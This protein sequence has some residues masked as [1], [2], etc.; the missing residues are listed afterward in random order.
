MDEILLLILFIGGGIFLAGFAVGYVIG[1]ASNTS[2]D[3]D[4]RLAQL[5]SMLRETIQHFERQERTTPPAETPAETPAG[6][7]AIVGPESPWKPSSIAL[8][9]PPASP[10]PVFSTIITPKTEEAGT[11]PEKSV[12]PLP[13]TLTP[14]PEPVPPSDAAAL[15]SRVSPI[16][17]PPLVAANETSLEMS[18]EETPPSLVEHPWAA[19]SASEK[20]GNRE[21]AD[22]LETRHSRSEPAGPRPSLLAQLW[23]HAN[24][25]ALY[26][27]L[28]NIWVLIGV[29]ILF[30]GLVFLVRLA[31]EQDFFT[32]PLRL[33]SAALIGS[34]LLALGWRLREKRRDLALI[35]QGGG[36]GALYLTVVAAVQLYELLPSTVAFV[37]L[38]CLVVLSTFLAI[39]QNSQIMAHV[40]NGAGFLAPILISTGSGNYIALFSYYIL[41]NLGIVG[42]SWYRHWRTLHLTGFVCTTLIGGLWG[43]HS[44]LPVMLP[45]IE[46]FLLVFFLLFTYLALAGSAVFQTRSL[47]TFAGGPPET[48]TDMPLTFATP[49]VFMLYQAWLTQGQPF[50]LAFTALALGVFYL[51]IAAFLWKHRAHT[52]VSDQLA[53]PS[54]TDSAFLGTLVK[55]GQSAYRLQAEIYLSFSIVFLN[56]ALPLAL[57]ELDIPDLRPR[58]LALAWVLEGAALYWLGRRHDL[59]LFRL[60]AAAG[61]VL[62]IGFQ[63]DTLMSTSAISSG[64][65]L[66][67]VLG[68]HLLGAACLASAS[69]ACRRFPG[70]SPAD[71]N[72]NF[73]HVFLGTAVLWW[74]GSWL[75][76]TAT[77]AYTAEILLAGTAAVATA[78]LFAARRLEWPE[79]RFATFLSYFP[80]AYLV[81]PCLPPAAFLLYANSSA[82]I[83]GFFHA[84]F[85]FFPVKSAAILLF[86]VFEGALLSPRLSDH[87]NTINRIRLAVLPSLALPALVI[88]ASYLVHSIPLLT[89]SSIAPLSSL[90]CTLLWPVLIVW[91]VPHLAT[92][93]FPDSRALRLGTS[94][95]P[96]L[97]LLLW[98]LIHV[99]SLGTALLPFYLPLFNTVEAGLTASA[100]VLYL[101]VKTMVRQQPGHPFWHPARHPELWYGLALAVATISLA[102]ACAFWTGME[103]SISDALRTPVFQ[104]VLALFWGIAGISAMLQ[105]SRRHSR[106]LWLS[107]MSLMLVDIVK[108]LFIDLT[109]METIWRIV[110]FMGVGILLILIGYYSPLPPV[111]AQPEA[112]DGTSGNTPDTAEPSREKETVS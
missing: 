1:R 11:G 32:P 29:T 49:L 40:A 109:R 17:E 62:G 99:F 68:L 9:V 80:L 103:F 86:V 18:G 63:I 59:V 19:T 83:D 79:L 45:E 71:T 81:L 38:V 16:V 8:S 4:V 108:L 54:A 84:P 44:F 36:V 90:L 92:R 24:R 73:E 91:G 107:G 6:T 47:R 96:L 74:Y 88:M 14:E 20:S 64:N 105:G 65:T 34:G 106:L 51:W 110:A 56:L 100:L 26:L 42:I 89:Q 35:L 41:L 27:G 53:G 69:L 21:E 97:C 10:L 2:R 87:E 52:I 66:P 98:M 22:I 33:A 94:A 43:A 77:F 112:P 95:L 28:S 46:A 55:L 5:S 3:L 23:Q 75:I 102:R 15:L 50:I 78:C 58:I 39:V 60:S 70:K 48:V 72:R 7:G 101:W 12:E 104:A 85:V 13:L 31:T 111:H 30:L 67:V 37:I 76:E 93:A 82:I 25:T 61:F 57:F